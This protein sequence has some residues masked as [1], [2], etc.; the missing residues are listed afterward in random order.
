MVVCPCPFPE[1]PRPPSRSSPDVAQQL[2]P[3][4]NLNAMRGPLR[5]SRVPPPSGAVR[6]L[7]PALQVLQR[8]ILRAE[9]PR[10]PETPRGERPHEYIAALSYG[11]GHREYGPP[12]GR[13]PSPR[14]RATASP[15]LAHPTRPITPLHASNYRQERPKKPP[16][17]ARDSSDKRLSSECGTEVLPSVQS[18]RSSRHRPLSAAAQLWTL[19]EKVDVSEVWRNQM[20][21]T[22]RRRAMAVEAETPRREEKKAGTP[23]IGRPRSA[24]NEDPMDALDGLLASLDE[25]RVGQAEQEKPSTPPPREQSTP[26]LA[27]VGDNMQQVKSTPA[28][29]RKGRKDRALAAENWPS[30]AGR[31]GPLVY[32]EDRT[33]TVQNWPSVVGRAGPLVYDDEVDASSPV[34]DLTDSMATPSVYCPGSPSIMSV[35]MPGSPT[36]RSM[37]APA[38]MDLLLHGFEAAFELEPDTASSVVT[39]GE[40]HKAARPTARPCRVRVECRGDG[41]DSNKYAPQAPCRRPL[42]TGKISSRPLGCTYLAAN[43]G[44]A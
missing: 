29:R 16:L 19:E 40:Q 1:A 28:P 23:A 34:V 25:E 12:L 8:S 14:E 44:G 26:Q 31:T 18:A 33:A 11:S 2:P 20:W 42:G 3:R 43:S 7:S 15:N 5:S 32:D 21:P 9:S 17:S 35:H 13:L 27:F 30:S 38:P 37:T 24:L 10:L 4:L 36:P 39:M 22:E 41:T 6:S